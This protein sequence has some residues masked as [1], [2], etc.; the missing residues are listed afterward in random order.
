MTKYRFAYKKMS[1]VNNAGEIEKNNL[2][3]F[4]TENIRKDGE[5]EIKAI[6]MSLS[7]FFKYLTNPY[8]CRYR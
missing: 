2:I 7:K 3:N 6:A 5:L 1:L 8:L 4:T